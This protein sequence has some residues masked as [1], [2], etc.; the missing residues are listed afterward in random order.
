M[1][2]QIKNA[3]DT[4]GGY[5]ASNSNASGPSVA[6]GGTRI[7]NDHQPLINV[8]P[9]KREDLQPSYASQLGPSDDAA[10]HGWYGGMSTFSVAIRHRM[11]LTCF[12]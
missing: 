11:L 6:A 3:P 1:T 2:D 12:S 8:Q 9:L 10:T 7:T 5:R 4:N